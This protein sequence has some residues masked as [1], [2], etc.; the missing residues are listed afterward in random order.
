ML[1]DGL[2]V[3]LMCICANVAQSYEF[4]APSLKQAPWAPAVLHG[5]RAVPFR[6]PGAE[7]LR[8]EA[9]GFLSVARLV[10]GRPCPPKKFKT[11]CPRSN[12]Q[13]MIWTECFGWCMKAASHFAG[14]HAEAWRPNFRPRFQVLPRTR[15]LKRCVEQAAAVAG[16]RLLYKGS[17]KFGVLSLWTRR[18][19]R[20]GKD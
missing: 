6:P 2:H 12:P 4:Q 17:A 15:F 10:W 11:M 19:H 20:A 7:G 9:A 5:P 16:W 18:S 3:C 14:S 1:I 13:L 8:R